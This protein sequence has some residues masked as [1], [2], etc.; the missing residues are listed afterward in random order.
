MECEQAVCKMVVGSVRGTWQSP[1]MPT[2]VPRLC[3]TEKWASGK[4]WGLSMNPHSRRRRGGRFRLQEPQA[5]KALKGKGS[6]G[7]LLDFGT[8]LGSDCRDHRTTMGKEAWGCHSSGQPPLLGPGPGKRGG[9]GTQGRK[10]SGGWGPRRGGWPGWRSPSISGQDGVMG[11]SQR[12]MWGHWGL[13]SHD[14]LAAALAPLLPR[15][16]DGRCPGLVPAGCA[17]PR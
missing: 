4:G 1:A 11:A 17:H 6:G 3:N 15:S 9:W 5:S 12:T 10:G 13:G 16:R 2:L 14:F 7:A 8:I